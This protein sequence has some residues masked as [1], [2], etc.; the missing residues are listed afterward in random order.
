MSLPDAIRQALF[1]AGDTGN[2]WV[3][4]EDRSF[5][6]ELSE[7]CPCDPVNITETAWLTME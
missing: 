3:H 4:S 1:E 5:A 7:D 2:V 6:H